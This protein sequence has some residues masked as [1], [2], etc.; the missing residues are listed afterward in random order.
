M[1]IEVPAGPSLRPTNEAAVAAL[2]TPQA[3][4]IPAGLRVEGEAHYPCDV[5]LDGEMHGRLSVS[6]SAT[7]L[8]TRNGTADG[9]VTAGDTFVEGTVNGRIDCSEGAVEFSPSAR[10]TA[11]VV[12]RELSVARGAEVDA[13]LQQVGGRRV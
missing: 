8:V 10:C 11:Q 9:T 5:A 12:Y 2:R 6:K 3:A 7:L 1:N 13:E 4:R